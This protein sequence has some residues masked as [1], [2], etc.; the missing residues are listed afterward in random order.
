[1]E[2]GH[3]YAMELQSQRVW[4]Y[5]NDEYVHRLIR[6]KVDGQHYLVEVPANGEVEPYLDSQHANYSS[7]E[8]GGLG[9]SLG[10]GLSGESDSTKKGWEK[11]RDV[12][13]TSKIEAIT[14]EYNHLLTVQLDSQSKY[15]EEQLQEMRQKLSV[16]QEDV[17]KNQEMAD[18]ALSRARHLES[19]KRI[20]EKKMAMYCS[21]IEETEKENHF[22]R[23]LNESLL[24][25]KKK[26]QEELQ[27]LKEGTSEKDSLIKDLKEQV[28]D[29][30]SHLEA[31]NVVSEE[32]VGASLSLPGEICFLASLF[33]FF[34][35]GPF[36]NWAL[37]TATFRLS[38]TSQLKMVS[39]LPQMKQAAAQ[40]Q[41][42][43]P[44]THG[45]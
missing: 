26:W 1:M 10:G 9:F 24:R 29:I 36:L 19:S 15:F 16:G 2:T 45:S 28:R 23:Q 7:R 20:S 3:C 38:L 34:F 30:I 21:K 40:A 33:S 41:E 8:E 18:A 31:K 32:M 14:L 17:L 43:M 37:A 5:V 6:S 11:N 42:E 4:D 13:L 25:D 12:I 22:L 35:F 44:H 27:R 39:D